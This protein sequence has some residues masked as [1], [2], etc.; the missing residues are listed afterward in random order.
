MKK[1][2]MIYLVLIYL[3]LVKFL[4]QY[5]DFGNVETNWMILLI[6]FSIEKLNYIYKNMFS[7][8][9]FGPI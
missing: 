4:L 6:H 9:N 1:N 5:K 8:V 3:S 7:C 2:H